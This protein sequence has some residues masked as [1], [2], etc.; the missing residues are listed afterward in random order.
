MVRKVFDHFHPKIIF[1]YN[2]VLKLYKKKPKIFKFNSS[3]PRNEKT[4]LLL[5]Q[6]V[7]RYNQISKHSKEVK[8]AVPPL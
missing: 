7:E 1:S 4:D 8:E 6:I 3:I 2:D 5:E